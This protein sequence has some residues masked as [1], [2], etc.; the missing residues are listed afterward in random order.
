MSKPTR[1]RP[2]RNIFF[3]GELEGLPAAMLR[4]VGHPGVHSHRQPRKQ[5]PMSSSRS[6]AREEAADQRADLGEKAFTK[7]GRA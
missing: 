7:R 5:E 3:G 1:K 2:A 4:D 6:Q